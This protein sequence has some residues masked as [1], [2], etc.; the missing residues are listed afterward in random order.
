MAYVTAPGSM[1]VYL[2]LSDGG[3]VLYVGRTHKP[4]TRIR[5]H[6]Q[7][8]TWATSIARV[9]TFGPFSDTRSRHLERWLIEQLEP[10]NNYTFTE[11]WRAAMCPTTV[12]GVAS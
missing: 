11:R 2:H 10:A 3:S 4:A 9:E 1:W 7:A 5:Q 6:L 8:S 12:V